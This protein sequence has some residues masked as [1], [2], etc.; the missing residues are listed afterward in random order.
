MSLLKI[1]ESENAYIS[2]SELI[3]RL[4]LAKVD[5]TVA[6]NFDFNLLSHSVVA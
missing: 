3:T 2:V 6:F 4:T 1:L 5:M